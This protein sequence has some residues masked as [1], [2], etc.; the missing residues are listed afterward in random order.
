M[1]LR[2]EQNL[3]EKGRKE[4]I[5]TVIWAKLLIIAYYITIVIILYLYIYID[6]GV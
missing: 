5:Y 2:T 3:V 4:S 6:V 1:R